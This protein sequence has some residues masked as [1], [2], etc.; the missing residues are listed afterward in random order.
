MKKSNLFLL[1]D[2][3]PYEVPLIYS[4]Y[5]LF[6]YI[7]SFSEWD[8]LSISPK[9][10]LQHTE[11]YS[12]FIYKN[13]ESLRLLHLVH[14][15]GQLQMTKFIEQFEKELLNYFTLNCKFSLRYPYKKSTNNKLLLRKVRNALTYILNNDT[16]TE[17]L[18]ITRDSY[19][20]KKYF[21]RI[22]D[23]YNSP[24]LNDLEIKYKYMLKMDISNCFY[25]IYTHSIDWAFLGS[26]ELAKEN[27][28]NSNRISYLLD[29]LMQAINY[30]ETN[31]IVVGPEFSRYIS[32]IIL[33]RIDNLVYL[34]LNK[35]NT[36]YIKDYQIHRFMDDIFVFF[37]DLS[38]GELIKK[39]YQTICFDFKLSINNQKTYIEYRPFLKNNTWLTNLR[40]CLENYVSK[41]NSDNKNL[42]KN[43][44]IHQNF[45]IHFKTI[46]IDYE[47]YNDNIISFTLSYFD[48]NINKIIKSINTL[49]NLKDISNVWKMFLDNL[50]HVI[51]F[52][53]SSS[54][55][56]KYCKII[57][58]IYN[59]S[60]LRKDFNTLELL[61]KKN[62]DILLYHNYR[63]IELLNL[64]IIMK[65][66]ER[67]LDEKILINFL[68]KDSSYFTLSTITYYIKKNIYKYKKTRN[69]INKIIYNRLLS[70]E[71]SYLTDITVPTPK[72]P[73]DHKKIKNLIFS[74]DFYL[75]HDFYSSEILDNFNM[76]KL[77][78][79]KSLIQYLKPSSINNISDVFIS[80]IIDFDKPF[81]QWNASEKD[82]IF[83][84]VN[85]A[86]VKKN[87]TRSSD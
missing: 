61:F 7:S 60:K 28:S 8:I 10:P 44:F 29:K 26:K 83:N 6:E 38:I 36:S 51:I 39:E 86:I 64:I 76:Q 74:K 1:T 5:P 37:N 81:M 16:L 9:K 13:K 21:T 22:T 30:N 15:L 70:L 79:F 82:I 50:Q 41:I 43:T 62:C 3:I 77:N 68:E 85:K 52:A 19:F 59:Y 4:N 23:F 25:N 57:S 56:I 31:G 35:S 14:P 20:D 75:I 45:I 54:N 11:P 24:E 80:Y 73:V 49:E 18:P 66:Y 40:D 69:L 12:F 47:K 67:D 53:I 32:E 2:I 65:E 42:L 71:D 63:N 72:D 34:N 33:M 27:I 48:N 55:I 58:T 78:Y 87:D 84:I 46:L 17:D